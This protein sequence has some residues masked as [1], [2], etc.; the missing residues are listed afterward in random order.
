M[1]VNELSR[2]QLDELKCKYFW[3]DEYTPC[4]YRHWNTG[5][6]LP[7]LFPCDIPDETIKQIFS[8]TYFVNDDFLCTA[9]K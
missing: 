1:T 2:A 3:S 4:L 5:E 7:V 6:L 9:G 8:D